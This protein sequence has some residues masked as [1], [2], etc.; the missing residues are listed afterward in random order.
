MKASSY[1]DN[2]EDARLSSVYNLHQ[3]HHQR[4]E[5]QKITVKITNTPIKES[6]KQRSDENKSKR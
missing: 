6:D 3:N 5:E 4:K 2:D 1:D